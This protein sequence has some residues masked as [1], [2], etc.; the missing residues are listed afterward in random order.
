MTLAIGAIVRGAA[1]VPERIEIAR[2]AG[3]PAAS[4]LRQI[5]DSQ[6]SVDRLLIGEIGGER[7]ASLGEGDVHDV[8]IDAIHFTL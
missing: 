4:S 8:R 5:D 7:Q 1:A 2:I 6:L 3:R